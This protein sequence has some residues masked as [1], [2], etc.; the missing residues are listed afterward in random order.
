MSSL[1]DRLIKGSF[2]RVLN[3]ISTIA[4]SLFMIPFVIRVIGDRWYG[5]WIFAASISGYYGFLDLGLS[6]AIQ[7]FISRALGA[8]DDREVNVIFNTCLFLFTIGALFVTITVFV[9]YAFCPHLVKYAEDVRTFQWVIVL[10][11]LDVALYFPTRAFI[12]FLAA[13]VRFEVINAIDLGKLIL[14]TALIV[15]FL[16]RGHGIIALAVIT[17]AVDAF[18]YLVIGF[19]VVRHF[20]ELKISRKFIVRGRIRPLFDYSAYVFIS[21]LANELR[22][23]TDAFVITAFM[24]L[25]AVTHFSIGS[26]I[27]D[28]YMKLVSSA[29]TQILPVFSKFEG[30]KDHAQLREKFLFVSKLTAILSVFLGGSIAL[31]GRAFI[32]RWMGTPYLDAF[33]VLA[34]L[35]FGLFFHTLLEPSVTLLYGLSKH[36]FYAIAAATEGVCNLI[37]SIILVRRFGLIG[38]ALGTTIPLVINS[39]FIIP[40]Y[41][42]RVLG[43]AT[44]TYARAIV[45]AIAF[46]LGVHGASWLIIRN[47]I[48]V[49]Y[50]RL[51]LL[52]TA[53]SVVFLIANIF[54]LL[55][56]RERSYFRIPF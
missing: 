6:V 13:H 17:I 33:A 38:V 9:I 21:F 5:L 11:G 34:I 53:T 25:S 32:L 35:L 55:T 31:Y 16:L 46:G 15:L 3:L 18:Q 45:P 24:N 48:T 27:A 39:V 28:Y 8:G 12:G 30:Q 56:K 40:L 52:A 37:L 1:A 4:V 43:L 47:M 19:Y 22:F 36:R 50:V 51:A 23:Y 20:P 44:S 26:R 54:V 49:G 7:R 41:T 10:V 29:V 2:L 42:N 14:R